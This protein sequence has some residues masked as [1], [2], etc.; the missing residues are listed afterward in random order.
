MQIS[1]EQGRFLGLVTK[2]LGAE[3]AVEVGTFTGY[4]SICI[5]RELAEGGRMLCC[6]VDEEWTAVARRY[7][8]EAGLSDRMELRLGPALE[9]LEAISEAPTWDVAFIDADK[10]SYPAYWNLVVARMRPGGVVMVD[11]V[12]R[13]GSVPDLSVTDEA[14]VL[15]REFNDL[16]LADPRVDS[17]ILP[18]SDGLTFA[19]VR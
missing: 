12:L 16:V 4:S 7:W 9:T 14:T 17:M 2:L 13:G 18:V 8:R 3:R 10:A 1:V 6:D 19:R 11:N 15:M 5:A